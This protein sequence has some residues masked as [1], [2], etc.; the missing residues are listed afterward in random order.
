MLRQ[1][2]NFCSVKPVGA[3]LHLTFSIFAEK[4]SVANANKSVVVDN[5]GQTIQ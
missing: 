1:K 5:T 3:N 4:P 2:L